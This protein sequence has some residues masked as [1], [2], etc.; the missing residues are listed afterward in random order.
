MTSHT[1]RCRG[2]GCLH[3]CECWLIVVWCRYRIEVNRVPAGNWIL[4]EGVDEPV[5]KTS[6]I[7][8]VTGNDDVTHHLSLLLSPPRA[9]LQPFLFLHYPSE[10]ASDPIRRE[11]DKTYLFHKSYPRGFTSSSR[12]AST[13]FCLHRF[14]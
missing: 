13:D 7:T 1:Q 5:V 12:T 6:T 3:S 8:E 11:R 9:F 4:M 10:S 2:C 14:F